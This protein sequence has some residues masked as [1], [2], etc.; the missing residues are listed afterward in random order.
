V[1]AANCRF[2]E[3]EA[4]TGTGDLRLIDS[5]CSGTLEVTS[6]TGDV[7]L[8]GGAVGRLETELGTGDVSRS[9][10]EVGSQD[11]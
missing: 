6:G 10:T 5:V 1:T 11:G 2:G 7:D 4:E 8:R 3:V 9:G